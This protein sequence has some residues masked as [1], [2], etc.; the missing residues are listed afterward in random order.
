MKR[1]VLLT[2]T[3]YVVLFSSCVRRHQCRSH[4]RV[5]SVY[6]ALRGYTST[7][8]YNHDS[9]LV[10]VTRS[11]GSK[12]VIEY[13]DKSVSGKTTDPNG[14]EA[15]TWFCFLNNHGLV[16]SMIKKDSVQI[17]STKKFIY[18]A[19]SFAI[20][21]REYIPNQPLTITRKTVGDGNIIM[22]TVMH[23]EPF[24]AQ[25]NHNRVTGKNDTV[26]ITTTGK[27]YT[28][29]NEYF[30]DK[31]KT[32]AFGNYGSPEFGEGTRNIEKRTIQISPEGDTIDI[33]LFRYGFDE[34]GRVNMCVTRNQAG[35]LLDSSYISYY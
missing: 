24:A 8:Y 1:I 4:L 28:V 21:E 33:S 20:E 31:E 14:R 25:I 18:D 11:N 7:Y 6:N 15:S 19:Q 5:K 13:T 3:F 29:Y 10:A 17:T 34:K 27:D 35:D 26:S 16:D 12:T 2:L 32:L 22:F 23:V 30:P 9:N